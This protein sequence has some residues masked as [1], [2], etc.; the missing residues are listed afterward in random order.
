M[1][2]RKQN[3]TTIQD[4]ERAAWFAR[5]AFGA[6][7]EKNIRYPENPKKPTPYFEVML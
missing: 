6:Y 7:P 3:Q 2:K 4:I 5:L 1:K